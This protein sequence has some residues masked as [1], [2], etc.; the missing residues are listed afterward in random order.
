[1][2]KKIVFK[3]HGEIEID[4]GRFDACYGASDLSEIA[5]TLD[6]IRQY[7][8]AEIVDVDLIEVSDVNDETK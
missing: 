4:I 7:G 8:T 6:Y 3:I 5:E 1:M 2:H